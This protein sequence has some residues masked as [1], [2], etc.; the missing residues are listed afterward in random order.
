MLEK[1]IWILSPPR[2]W[3]PP[4]RHR[5]CARETN[6]WQFEAPL[7]YPL[8]FE[9]AGPLK[10]PTPNSFLLLRPKEQVHLQLNCNWLEVV[11]AA[12][13][14]VQDD[15][16]EDFDGEHQPGQ[17]ATITT[18]PLHRRLLHPLLLLLVG[19][20]SI[21]ILFPTAPELFLLSPLLLAQIQPSSS[22]SIQEWMENCLC[23]HPYV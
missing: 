10:F 8:T 22:S 11:A 16:R 21:M 14:V 12:D 3:I 1:Q 7:S 19:G 13:V 2:P 4:Y 6:Q 20:S 9:K 5:L 15:D 17:L 23:K 18:P